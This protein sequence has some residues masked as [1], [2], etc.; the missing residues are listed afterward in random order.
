MIAK[1]S[2]IVAIDGKRVN[3]A[4]WK[5]IRHDEFVHLVQGE[6]AKRFKLERGK[7]VVRDTH[8]IVNGKLRMKRKQ[9]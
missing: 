7:L 8:E 5:D 6:S 9:R 3:P 2:D 1:G 4:E